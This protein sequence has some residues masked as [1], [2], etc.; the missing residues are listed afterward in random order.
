MPS[1]TPTTDAEWDAL[2][3]EALNEPEPPQAV[4]RYAINTFSAYKPANT[5]QP[6]TSTVTEALGAAIRLVTA[7]LTFD[8]AAS[9]RPA[10]GVRSAGTATRHMLFSAEGCEIDLRISPAGSDTMNVAGQILGAGAGRIVEISNEHTRITANLSELNEF[11][12]PQTP[13]GTYTLTVKLPD[14]EVQI[15]ALQISMP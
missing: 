14:R 13:R 10:F 5:A 8:S 3:R 9:T 6:L 15:S 1:S 12:L 2:V 11:T 7:T 4:L